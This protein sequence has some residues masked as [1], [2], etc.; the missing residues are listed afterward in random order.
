M[1]IVNH[2][3][4]IDIFGILIPN[5]L[6]LPDTNAATGDGSIG[7][8]AD[9]CAKTHNRKPNL[10]LVDYFNIGKLVTVVLECLA[11]FGQAMSSLLRTP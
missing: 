9:L 11:D 2:F 6:A 1:M 4:D 5:T 3:L 10:I 8:Q 7:S